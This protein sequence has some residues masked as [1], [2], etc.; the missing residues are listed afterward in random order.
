MD[1]EKFINAY[2]EL[3]NATMTESIQKNIVFQAQKKM[4]DDEILQLKQTLEGLRVEKKLSEEKL[5]DKIT[6]LNAELFEIRSKSEVAFRES[7]DIKKST[8]HIGTFKSELVKARSEITELNK[9]LEQYEKI[10]KKSVKKKVTPVTP[11]VEETVKDAG[12]F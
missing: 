11:I 12:S 9:R 10:D 4:A 8:Q 6:S 1:Q 7:E 5:S 2:V 3:L